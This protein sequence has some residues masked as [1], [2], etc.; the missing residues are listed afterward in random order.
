MP[1]RE[2]HRA[3]DM[4]DLVLVETRPESQKYIHD[5]RILHDKEPNTSIN[6]D[7]AVEYIAA[8]QDTSTQVKV[9]H[10]AELAVAT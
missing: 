9:L 1:E 2:G 5:A 6:P 8:V 3:E 7:E 10:N 4:H